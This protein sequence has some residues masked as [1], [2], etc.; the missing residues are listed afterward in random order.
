MAARRVAVVTGGGSGIGAAICARFAADGLAVIVADRDAE[1]AGRVAA[2]IAATGGEAAAAT[3][4]AADPASV[5]Q[6]MAQAETQFGS[7]DVMVAS[8]GIGIQ[9]SMLETT[10]AEWNAIIAVNLTGVFLCGQ[11]AAARMA[12]RGFG[13]IINISAVAGM[14]GIPGRC[15]YGASKGGVNSLTQVMAVE[16]GAFGITVN[17]I[18]PGPI[19]TPLTDRMHTEATRRAYTDAMPL[20]RYGTLAE[21]AGVASFLASDDAAFVTGHVLPVDGGMAAAGPSFHV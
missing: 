6:A 7:L 18:A 12:P 15:A 16:F 17:A 4:D 1:N 9:K 10:F 11:A 14:R 19:N 5:E 8:A 13:R 21:A 3:M 20:R 2:D